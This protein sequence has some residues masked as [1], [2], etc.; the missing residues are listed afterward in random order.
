MQKSCSKMGR[1]VETEGTK[2]RSRG[3]LT[4]Q[5]HS[6]EAPHIVRS[7]FIDGGNAGG[8]QHLFQE[9]TGP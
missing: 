9:V 1:D 4:G 7:Q 8:G 2:V 6:L 3:A 5:V